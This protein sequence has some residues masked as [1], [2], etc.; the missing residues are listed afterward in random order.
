MEV[1]PKKDV[2][3]SNT[4]HNSI[5]TEY[6]VTAFAFVG[7]YSWILVH[8]SDGPQPKGVHD[9]GGGGYHITAARKGGM[10]ERK[11]RRKG[12]ATVAYRR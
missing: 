7:Q 5:L 10:A 9:W 12:G 3:K 6:V 2:G 1:Y 11:G 8:L 4:A